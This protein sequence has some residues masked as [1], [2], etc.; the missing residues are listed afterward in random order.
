MHEVPTAC[1]VPLL[2]KLST[3]DDLWH[4]WN[5][6]GYPPPFHH[7]HTNHKLTPDN[8]DEW[9]TFVTN[10]TINYLD[11]LIELDLTQ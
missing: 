11:T 9:K 1:A 2:L 3:S 5:G 6:G 4:P 10:N 7:K 8:N